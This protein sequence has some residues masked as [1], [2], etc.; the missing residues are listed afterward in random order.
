M[1]IKYWI[2]LSSI[3]QI[4]SVFIQKLF[5]Y[6]GDIEPSGVFTWNDIRIAEKAKYIKFVFKDKASLG[7]VAFYDNSHKLLEYSSINNYLMDE[8]EIIPD[9]ISYM[10]SSYFDEVYFARTAYQ[11]VH[12]M[13]TYE[14]THPPLGKLIQAIPIYITGQFSPFMYRLMNN[15]SGILMLV[16]MYVL[17]LLMFKKRK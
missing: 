10:N 15:V 11:Y 1:N 12:G 13:K 5:E 6:Y 9:K 3:E 8:T 16:V 2:G 17:G 7:E 4:D 14:W